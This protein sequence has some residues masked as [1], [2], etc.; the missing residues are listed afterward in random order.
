[1]VP[2]GTIPAREAGRFV[3]LI[4]V[5][6]NQPQSHMVCCWVGKY[7]V[8]NNE[9]RKKEP[10]H[11]SRSYNGHSLK[12]ER[13]PVVYVNFDDA[14]A[15]AEWLTQEDH[16]T[17]M[18]LDGYRYRVPSKEEWKTFAQCGRGWEYPWGNIYPPR[19]GRAGNYEDE[20]TFG[21]RR[22]EEGYRDGHA[23][24]CDVEDSWA[25]PWGLCGVGGNVWEVTAEDGDG[26][27]FGA[28]RG[29]SWWTYSQDLLRCSY[30][31]EG[32]GAYRHNDSGFRLVLS[33]P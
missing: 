17:G 16:A 19:S 26:A 25:N 30:G 14:V 1:M 11:D 8:T 31:L 21:N 9:Y 6:W 4:E 7:E 10:H 33:R 12:R 20:T 18:L 2:N 22:D 29:A 24:T 3:I 27:S 32:S 15:Y 13:Q 23:V 28:W 5:R